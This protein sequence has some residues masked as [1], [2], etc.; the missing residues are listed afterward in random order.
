MDGG[1]QASGACLL[2]RVQGGFGFC[3]LSCFNPN[4]RPRKQT[5]SHLRK[6]SAYLP[7]EA[8]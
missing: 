2:A 1:D 3:L 7:F 8:P 6:R 4:I 5:L